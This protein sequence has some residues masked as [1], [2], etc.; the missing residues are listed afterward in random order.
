MIEYSYTFTNTSNPGFNPKKGDTV[1]AVY[2][3]VKDIKYAT[4]Q[5]FCSA[6]LGYSALVA[7]VTPTSFVTP[8][9]T[10]TAFSTTTTTASIIDKRA[11]TS[12]SA[13][14]STPAVLK[15]YPA[16][17]MSSACSLL[18]SQATSTS[19]STAP[20]T[21]VAVATQTTLETSVLTVTAS[22]IPSAC[23]N[24]G[25]QYAFYGSGVYE[26]GDRVSYVE[27]SKYA[28]KQPNWQSTTNKVG[29]ID[30]DGSKIQI[31]DSGNYEYSQYFILNHR[32]YVSFFQCYH[33]LESVSSLTNISGL[34]PSR[35]YLHLLPVQP[36]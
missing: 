4:L 2:Q 20:P 34:C 22:P 24:K 23:G 30:V 27:P 10:K 32:G 13:S 18:V 7:T 35:W 3:A 6:A 11:A 21:T 12:D 31:Y 36:R 17:V 16:S 1:G 25:I 8:V 28:S 9:V 19:T 29:G 26:E 15:K 33:V 14:L 5:P